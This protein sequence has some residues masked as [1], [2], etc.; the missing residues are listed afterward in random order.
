MDKNGNPFFMRLIKNVIY[1]WHTKIYIPIY[2]I[3]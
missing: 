2:L 1:D 3:Y